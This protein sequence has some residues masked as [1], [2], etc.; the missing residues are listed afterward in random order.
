MDY[1]IPKGT[2]HTSVQNSTYEIP[3][4][5]MKTKFELSLQGCQHEKIS[6]FT[7]RIRTQDPCN[8]CK[9]F[10]IGLPKPD[11]G[12]P[13]KAVDVKIPVEGTNLPNQ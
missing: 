3:K 9:Y 2:S 5:T 11:T 13:H 8:S 7:P 6:K 4:G 10:D 12:S 1:M